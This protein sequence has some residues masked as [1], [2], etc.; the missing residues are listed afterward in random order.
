MIPPEIATPNG[1]AER[2]LEAVL[3]VAERRNG[4]RPD[5]ETVPVIPSS[6]NKFYCLR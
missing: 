3:D 5:L 6:R 4:E 1:L 2:M